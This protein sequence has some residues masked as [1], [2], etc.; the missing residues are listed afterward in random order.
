MTIFSLWEAESRPFECL[1]SAELLMEPVSHPRT[2]QEIAPDM[3][4]ACDLFL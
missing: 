3:G 4:K 1:V 2:R